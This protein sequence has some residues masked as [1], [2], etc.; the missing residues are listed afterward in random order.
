VTQYYTPQQA[1]SKDNNDMLLDDVQWTLKRSNDESYEA[2]DGDGSQNPEVARR[3]FFDG[4]GHVAGS[5]AVLL[6]PCNNNM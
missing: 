3:L 6:D 2:T 1:E 4:D 5:V